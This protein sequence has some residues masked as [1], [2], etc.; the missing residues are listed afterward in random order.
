[1]E[2]SGTGGGLDLLDLVV[3][4]VTEGPE[5]PDEV[6]GEDEM[7]LDGGLG[8]EKLRE[9]EIMTGLES[10]GFFPMIFLLL[11]ADEDETDRG[12]LI[13][14]LRDFFEVVFSIF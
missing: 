3:T 5:D 8:E 4:S 2:E 7:K 14:F 1:M 11:L 10:F 9:A 13:P 12:F 6:E